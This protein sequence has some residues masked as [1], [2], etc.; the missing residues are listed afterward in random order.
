MSAKPKKVDPNYVSQRVLQTKKEIEQLKLELE[1]LINR[2]IDADKANSSTIIVSGDRNESKSKESKNVLSI[3]LHASAQQNPNVTKKPSSTY[4]PKKDCRKEEISVEVSPKKTRHYNVEEAREYMRKQKE[5]RMEKIKIQ[6]QASQNVIDIRK[7]KLK[8]L[9]KRSLELVQK[10]ITLKRERSRSRERNTLPEKEIPQKEIK[11]N[12]KLTNKKQD[13]N[14]KTSSDP[15]NN[16]KDNIDNRVPDLNVNNNEEVPAVCSIKDQNVQTEFDLKNICIRNDTKDELITFDDLIKQDSDIR[17][18]AALKI[19]SCYRRYRQR[20]IFKSILKS[21][22]RKMNNMLKNIKPVLN[23]E[24]TELIAEKPAQNNVPFWLQTVVE[25]YP[26]NFI[27]AVKKKLNLATNTPVK[28]SSDIGVQISIEEPEKVEVFKTTNEIRKAIT[29]SLKETGSFTS[30]KCLDLNLTKVKELQLCD[31]KFRNLKND[32]DIHRHSNDNIPTNPTHSK[33]TL[34]KQ[35]SDTSESD[36]SKNIPDISSE[37]NVSSIHSKDHIDIDSSQYKLNINVDKLKKLKLQERKLNSTENTKLIL[38]NNTHKDDKILLNEVPQINEYKDVSKKS[39]ISSKIQENLGSSISL[40]LKH[41]LHPSVTE[42]KHSKSAENIRSESI[43]EIFY[44][45]SDT[46]SNISNSV[47]SQQMSKSETHI[48]APDLNKLS[49]KASNLILAKNTRSESNVPKLFNHEKLNRDCHNDIESDDNLKSFLEYMT[50]LEDSKKSRSLQKRS[51]SHRTSN[52]FKT[53]PSKSQ[54]NSESV[55]DAIKTD[56]ENSSVENYSSN[57]S[58]SATSISSSV[59]LLKCPSL[60][61]TT[62]ERVELPLQEQNRNSVSI[63][64]G[65]IKCIETKVINL[66]LFTV[67]C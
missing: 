17:H 7:E 38:S 45:K 21:K 53:L 29:E 23:T 36:T 34:V 25:P 37:S 11:T 8:E 49:K 58:N 52:S 24:N 15:T 61:L 60:T 27:S 32:C 31:E 63:K 2:G 67:N 40:K 55:T 39:K 13:S 26:Y 3:P 16:C 42:N 30:R 64:P 57:F 10:N 6:M 41:I 66:L 50:S 5:K 54:K 4:I 51:S 46:N 22:R 18:K 12:V 1:K 62:S 14:T 28:T 33:I 44:Q 20:K 48:S 43:K 59:P 47:I 9:Q 56:K 19:Q 35:G 65:E